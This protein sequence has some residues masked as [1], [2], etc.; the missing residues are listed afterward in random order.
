MDAND[1]LAGT[2][3][4]GQKLYPD[5][6]IGRHS[7][8]GDSN[9]SA[10]C[11]GGVLKLKRELKSVCPSRKAIREASVSVTDL[12]ELPEPLRVR[13]GGGRGGLPVSHR[14]A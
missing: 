3:K 13:P 9:C 7:D 14:A 1:G 5:I 8:V 4:F 6:Y 10:L 2:L 12:P 11:V